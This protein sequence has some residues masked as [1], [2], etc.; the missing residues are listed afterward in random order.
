[1]GRWG[2]FFHWHKSEARVPK[3]VEPNDMTLDAVVAMLKAYDQRK[4]LVDGKPPVK[5]KAAPKKKK[6]SGATARKAKKAPAKRATA[7]KS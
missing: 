4:G 3:G 5:K 7:K 1:M 6:A 2:P